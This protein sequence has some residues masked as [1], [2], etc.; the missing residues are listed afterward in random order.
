MG[1]PCLLPLE[2]SLLAELNQDCVAAAAEFLPQHL[3]RHAG[4]TVRGQLDERVGKAASP[5]E[6][7]VAIEP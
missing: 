7:D 3:R 4:R 5:G 1:S 2:L 6:S